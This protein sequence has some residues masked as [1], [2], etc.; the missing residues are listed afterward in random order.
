MASNPAPGQVTGLGADNTG[1]VGNKAVQ[2]VYMRAVIEI[3]ERRAFR[4]C[5]RLRTTVGAIIELGF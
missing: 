5:I 1:S 4:P 3:T 2:E